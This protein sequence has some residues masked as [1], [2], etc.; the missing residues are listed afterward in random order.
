MRIVNLNQYGKS[1]PIVCFVIVCAVSV[2]F[3]VMMMMMACV[4]KLFQGIR[5]C[6]FVD[7]PK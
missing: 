5:I 3:N 1:S 2:P 4:G 7:L 6:G